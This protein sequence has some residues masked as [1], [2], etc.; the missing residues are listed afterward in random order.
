MYCN[1]YNIK[2]PYGTNTEVYKYLC[3]DSHININMKV[4]ATMLW[5]FESLPSKNIYIK[6]TYYK[7]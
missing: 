4:F 7:L 1:Y 5:N 2:F 3:Y 6:A